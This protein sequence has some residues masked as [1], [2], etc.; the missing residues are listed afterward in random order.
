MSIGVIIALVLIIVIIIVLVQSNSDGVSVKSKA[1]KKEEIIKKY[2][3]DLKS[4]LAK[5]KD[6]KEQQIAQK[7]L[8]L[9]KCSSEFSRNIFFSEAEA[10]QI[11]QKLALL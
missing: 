4:I 10:K 2:E 7:K 11:I 3:D 5:H 8:F 1:L 6:N 9:Q